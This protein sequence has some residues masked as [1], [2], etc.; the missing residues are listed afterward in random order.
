MK[1]ISAESATVD[2]N[3]EFQKP[4]IH[5]LLKFLS[6]LRICIHSFVITLINFFI[7]LSIAFQHRGKLQG[8]GFLCT[9]IV[10]CL[11]SCPLT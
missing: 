11:C 6:K 1:R 3:L 8:L 4:V 2:L 10:L 9:L 5:F 7:L